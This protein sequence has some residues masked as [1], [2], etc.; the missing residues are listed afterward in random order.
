MFRKIYNACDYFS[1]LFRMYC[2][3]SIPTKLYLHTLF[4]SCGGPFHLISDFRPL[5]NIFITLHP[6][7]IW[8]FNKFPYTPLSTMSLI[9][10]PL[11]IPGKLQPIRILHLNS[12]YLPDFFTCFTDPSETPLLMT[13]GIT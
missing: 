8:K 11:E 3:G 4:L 13:S 9:F 5:R 1:L 6:L 7:E 2:K 12:L 10:G